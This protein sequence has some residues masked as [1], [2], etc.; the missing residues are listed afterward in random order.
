MTSPSSSPDSSA[1]EPTGTAVTSTPG[2][3][4]R[5]RFIASDTV[6]TCAPATP[7]GATPNTGATGGIGATTGVLP[8]DRLGG[9]ADARV[10]GGAG[11]RGGMRGNITSGLCATHG[12]S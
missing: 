5:L 2:G 11:T 9:G 3:R 4:S 6:T 8:K 7:L 10:V 1:G 12:A